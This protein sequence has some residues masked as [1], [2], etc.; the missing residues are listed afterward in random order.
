MHKKNSTPEDFGLIQAINFF[1]EKNFENLMT[2][3][4]LLLFNRNQ[5]NENLPEIKSDL[6][7]FK[8]FAFIRTN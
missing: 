1:S 7:S 4:F 5:R 3:L 6:G 8:E 2:G